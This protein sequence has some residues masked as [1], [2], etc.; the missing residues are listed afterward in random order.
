[1]PRSCAASAAPAPSTQYRL[2]TVDGIEASSNS[3][4]LDTSSRST[5]NFLL[6]TPKRVQSPPCLSHSTIITAATLAAEKK[7]Q[8]RFSRQEE[9]QEWQENSGQEIGEGTKV[10]QSL[11]CILH[12]A[13]TLDP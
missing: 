8:T 6:A 2:V 13:K 12:N 11:E 3:F 7:A 10:P 9:E 4:R 5:Y 1:M